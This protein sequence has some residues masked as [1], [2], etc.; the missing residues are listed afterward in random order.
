[1]KI[2]IINYLGNQYKFVCAS[3]V[4]DI[5]FFEFK[6]NNNNLIHIKADDISKYDIKNISLTSVDYYNILNV[7]KNKTLERIYNINYYI[8]LN[9][10]SQVIYN[11][12]T[13]EYKKIEDD[14]VRYEKDL[15]YY[16]SILES[17][18]DYMID[19][20]TVQS[21]ISIE[22]ETAIQDISSKLG[23]KQEEVSKQIENFLSK[24]DN[25]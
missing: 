3:K 6:D 1:M 5:N 13:E 7:L 25:I 21:R 24:E 9:Y 15:K 17:I 8:K 16:Q 11:K 19:F 18:K 2:S 10:D 22:R 23:I 14:I 4:N 20:Q 12:D